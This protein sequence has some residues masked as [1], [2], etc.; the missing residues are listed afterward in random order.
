M[1]LQYQQKIKAVAV[2]VTILLEVEFGAV[3][4]GPRLTEFTE[5]RLVDLV[6]SKL[7]DASSLDILQ[8]V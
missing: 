8:H 5:S 6:R 1:T 2:C 4:K 3:R 7:R